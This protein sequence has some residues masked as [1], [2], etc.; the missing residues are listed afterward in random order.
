M[1]LTLHLN[2]CEFYINDEDATQV[3]NFHWSWHYF[4]SIETLYLEPRNN[5]SITCYCKIDWTIITPGTAFAPASRNEFDEYSLSK[6]CI[7]Y[8][9]PVE[10]LMPS[11]INWCEGQKLSIYFD[12]IILCD[13][14]NNYQIDCGM[15]SRKTTE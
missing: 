14:I 4:P 15:F 3:C 7:V 5:S 12:S 1:K 13:N 2:K 10:I 9:K 11:T 6:L 8:D